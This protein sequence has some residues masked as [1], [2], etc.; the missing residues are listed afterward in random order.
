MKP[1]DF[2]LSRNTFGRLVL[3]TDDG[4]VYE[5]IV[6]VRAF[7]ISAPD[8]GLALLDEEGHERA[9]IDS[10]SALA[11]VADSEVR[12]L[13]ETTLAE[14][15][16]TPRILR[17][18]QVSTF[19]TP[20]TWHVNTDRGETSFVLKGEEDIRLLNAASLL[21]TDRDGVQYRIPDI[22]ALDKHSRRLLDRFL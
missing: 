1:L 15:E 9:W 20:S 21:I 5:N 19:A 7:P 3:T 6:P 18:Q 10:L 11:S 4:Q 12:A 2:Q 14:R 8:A 13:I 22:A 16:F 17:L